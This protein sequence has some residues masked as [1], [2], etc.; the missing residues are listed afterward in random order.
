MPKSPETA[1]PSEPTL[2]KETYK[3]TLVGDALDTL[4]AIVADVIRLKPEWKDTPESVLN[5]IILDF[6]DEV[7]PFDKFI[8]I[9]ADTQQ[10]ALE[11]EIER[12]KELKREARSGSLREGAS[13]SPATPR[14]P[15]GSNARDSSSPTGTNLGSVSPAAR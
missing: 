15:G 4:L 5:T 9:R 11:L 3:V 6:L 14:T 1:T 8:V 10:R 7:D 12:I 2:A 13:E